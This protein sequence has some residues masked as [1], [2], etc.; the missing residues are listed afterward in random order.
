[1]ENSHE[2]KLRISLNVL[3][4]LGVNLYSNIPAVISE[5]V[6]NSWD[7]DAKEVDILIDQDK[8]T[9]TVTDTGYG[10][11]KNDINEKY[12]TVGYHRREKENTTTPSGRHVM[13]RKGIGK[14]ALFSIADK[15][16]VHSVKVDEEGDISKCG[17]IMDAQAIR[18]RIQESKKAKNGEEE[19]EDKLTEY[20]PMSVSSDKVTID[21]GTKIIIHGVKKDMSALETNL[22]RKLA[23]RFSIIGPKNDF[24]VKVGGTEIGVADRDYFNKLQ[25]IW[26][27]G[28]DSKRYLDECKNVEESAMI[29]PDYVGGNQSYKVTGW[30]GTLNEHK[31]V[32]EGNNTVTVLSWGKLI[33]E[34]ILK[35]IKEGGVFS[36]YLIGEINADFLDY[37]DKLDIAT[38]GRQMVKEDD[39]RY[40]KLKEYVKKSIIS[41]IGSNWEPWRQKEALNKALINPKIKEWYETLSTDRAKYAVK[42]FQKIESF[43]IS[44]PEFKKEL[45]KNSI[46]AFETLSYKET[47]SSLDTITTADEFVKFEKILKDIDALEAVHYHEIV[48]GRIQV[49]KKFAEITP[50]AR[51]STIQKYLFSHLWLLDP[52][53]ERATTNKRIEQSV[54]R[55]FNKINAKL[56]RE[57][58]LGRIDIRYKTAAGKHIIVELKKE[59]VSVDALKLYEQVRKYRTAL[60]KCLTK[61]QRG[62]EKPF[63]EIVCVIGSDPKQ[64][65]E[66][67]EK[68]LKVINARY[69]TYE[70]LIA[71]TIESYNDYI[72]ASENI[73]RI[74][75]LVDSI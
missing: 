69:I 71:N 22:K 7:A 72:E 62:N 52:S 23:R 42:L 51:E 18:D 53:W 8:K 60:E 37:D 74:L 36:K 55:E 28:G 16:E 15:I 68:V 73:E 70:H 4:D 63:I 50:E 2:Y 13:G 31:S 10:M 56:S 66:E 25:Y 11:N 26:Y 9:I 24:C 30:I 47:L 20:Y 48:K 65:A 21:K 34:D 17:F 5:A 14:L 33:H 3:D 46:L 75:K 32:E 44:D 39:D 54:T 61:A 59:K 27:L 67:S 64:G 49:L 29:S 12:L 35:D 45:Y 19:D 38:S 6:A 1:M 57:E 58:K 41:K 40:I 43:P